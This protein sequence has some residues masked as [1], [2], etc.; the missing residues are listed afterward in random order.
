MDIS[1]F[2]KNTY[3]GLHMACLGG[4]WMTVVNGFL[5]MRHYID[6]LHFNPQIPSAWNSYCLKLIYRGARMEVKVNHEEATF[7]LLSGESLS[8]KIKET[9]V[10]LS[11]D[12]KS[13][14][15]QIAF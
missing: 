2:K 5:G 1:D 4:V 6:G 8:F 13:F 7:T 14:V 9:D 15:S 10:T 11:A 12:N 3:D